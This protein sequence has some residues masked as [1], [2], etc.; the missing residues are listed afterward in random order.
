VLQ[1]DADT[2]VTERGYCAQRR[3]AR[4]HRRILC[5]HH[6][7]LEIAFGHQMLEALKGL[8]GG[9]IHL[10]SRLVDRPDRDRLAQR[11][12]RFKKGRLG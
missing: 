6:F 3:H 4:Q 5:L 2:A 10:P 1:G 9:K 11:F 8:N 7:D 12:E